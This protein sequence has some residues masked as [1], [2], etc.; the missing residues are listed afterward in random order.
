MTAGAA[1]PP[2]R[3]AAGAGPPDR[4]V[5]SAS[6]SDAARPSTYLDPCEHTPA[7]VTPS[8]V[9]L[10]E[11]VI[12]DLF[13]RDG[14]SLDDSE[15]V[16]IRFRLCRPLNSA[17]APTLR[18]D[19]HPRID[20]EGGADTDYA[21][22]PTRWVLFVPPPTPPEGW[23]WELHRATTTVSELV[24]TGPVDI[25]G[26]RDELTELRAAVPPSQIRAAGDP[27][28]SS[29][30]GLPP[31]AIRACTSADDCG[32]GYQLDA[33]GRNRVTVDSSSSAVDYLPEPRH[34]PVTYPSFCQHGPFPGRMHAPAQVAV[35][36]LS[37]TRLTARGWTR[38]TTLPDGSAVFRGT[39]EAVREVAPHAA[40][41]RVGLRR[42]SIEPDDPYYPAD[43]EAAP[44]G[45]WS[46]RRLGAP[47]AWELTTG[48]QDVLVA[49]L[50]SGFDGLH[51]DLAGRAVA[52]RDYVQTRLTTPRPLDLS[53][54]TDF[55]G[56]GS[57]VAS[58]IG[59]ATDDGA[60]MAGLGWRT[61]LLPARVF[62]AESCASDAALI[63]AMDWAVRQGAVAINLSL[64]GPET[65]DALL[66][67]G[68]AAAAA[69]VIP[70]A[71]A[72]N[73]GTLAIEYPAFYDPYLSVTA[74]GYA[75]PGSSVEDPIAS[76]STR[77][78]G[79]DIAAPGGSGSGGASRDVLGACWQD[80]VV[81][82]GYCRRAG[83]S[84]STPLVAATIALAR[85]LDPGRT[86][87]G[88][89]QLLDDTALDLT[90][91]TA[92]EPGP[93]I[94]SGSGRLRTGRAISWLGQRAETLE[95]VGGDT[96]A[97]AGS[98][99]A[100]QA[101]F[102]GG[103]ATKALLSRDDVFADA[104]AGAPLAGADGPILLTP[105]QELDERT[106]GELV[107]VLPKGATVTL[108]GGPDAL[109]ARVLTDV[110]AL[111][112]RTQRL[113][114][115]TRIETA[116]EIADRVVRATGRQV[117]VAS[118][119]NWPDAI[120]GGAYAAATGVP[121]LL[122]WPDGADA[123]RS[124]RFLDTLAAYAPSDVV[125][126]GGTAAVSVDTQRQ[127]EERVPGVTR[128]VSGD[129]RNGTAARAVTELWTRT[130]GRTGDRFVIV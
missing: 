118:A 92:C 99:T 111:G 1:P 96:G 112:Y 7:G 119:A 87:Q 12:D 8:P 11:L 129:T 5:V 41:D 98:V 45:Q 81:Q 27:D 18:V 85:D 44:T 117:L 89:R 29:E 35:D 82:R 124:P 126:L 130:T 34:L 20:T 52:G 108:L 15:P 127:I 31:I 102:A 39:P 48:E 33:L 122:T 13:Q 125:L 46:L 121:L 107:R 76:Y 60:G 95:I 17:G 49:V 71:A 10:R 6:G 97:V 9:D 72:G 113:W 103:G 116:V 80:P 37:A 73:Q 58:M 62:D 128:R 55:G 40:V 123:A 38:L 104:L 67:A 69:G 61:G 70:V 109:S 16:D 51:P 101:T 32:P 59:A 86:V 30:T 56:H 115:P 74:T 105:T 91:C 57:F 66:A 78:K 88:L 83:T 53:T 25:V 2:D 19:L 21:E 14:Q 79:V 22:D 54:D 3:G 120:A 50:D 90:A 23:T 84:F 75:E 110:E 106:A 63:D 64:G 43:G 28:T 65:S 42:A 68:E 93:D 100:S 77:N 114:G 24:T 47:E 94:A 26:P 4:E 36:P